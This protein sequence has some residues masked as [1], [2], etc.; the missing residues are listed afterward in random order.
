[1]IGIVVP[2]RRRILLLIGIVVLLLRI[3]LLI[4][5]TVGIRNPSA[6]LIVRA[7]RAG[8]RRGSGSV[9]ITG[10]ITWIV[11]VAGVV[12]IAGVISV[13]KGSSITQVDASTVISTVG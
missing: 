1:M 2:L 13:P 9:S 11:G 6:I 5:I 4:G 12:G 8:L 10:G 3:L 7:W